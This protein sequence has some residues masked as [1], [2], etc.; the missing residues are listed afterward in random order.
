MS[1]KLFANACAALK[2]VHG[3]ALMR[4]VQSKISTFGAGAQLVAVFD[5]HFGHERGVES[6]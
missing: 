4:K 1:N 2:G 5:E 3:A 6:Q